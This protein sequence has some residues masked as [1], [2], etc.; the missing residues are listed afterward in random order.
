MKIHFSWPLILALLPAIVTGV[1]DTTYSKELPIPR[2]SSDTS[3]VNPRV[4]DADTFV[5]SNAAS[6]GTLDVP[7]D[8]KDG[9]PHAGPWVETSAERDRKS[10][11]SSDG[12]ELVSTKYDSKISSSDHLNVEGGKVI[13]YSNAGVMDDPHRVAPKEGT[14]GTEGG[15]S[16]KRKETQL[17]SEKVPGGPKE[18]PPLPHSEQRRLFSSE[19]TDGSGSRSA[20]GAGNLVVCRVVFSQGDATIELMACHFRNPQTCP[21]NHTISHIPNRLFRTKMTR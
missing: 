14:R 9:R 20:D 15:V 5:S 10:F 16:E 13:P 12:I 17:S 21:R 7:V 6:R 8:R 11:K 2:G 19:G 4:A 18:A 1:A 3:N